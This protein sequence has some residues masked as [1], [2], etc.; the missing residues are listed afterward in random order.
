MRIMLRGMLQETSTRL[1][2][3]QKQMLERL[4]DALMGNQRTATQMM[5]GQLDDPTASAGNPGGQSAG[6]RGVEEGR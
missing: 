2:S 3:E 6:N 1:M 5:G 4:W